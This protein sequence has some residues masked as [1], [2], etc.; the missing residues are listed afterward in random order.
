MERKF[1]CKQID[2]Q[3]R[4]KYSQTNSRQQQKPIESVI[5][6]Y[7]Y[8]IRMLEYSGKSDQVLADQ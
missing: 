8:T 3:Q 6:E 4:K 2:R 7:V 1:Y 5:Y